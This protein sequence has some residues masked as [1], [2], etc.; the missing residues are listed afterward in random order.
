MQQILST[1]QVARLLGVKTYQI[2]YA[3]ATHALDEPA[4]RF[5]GKRVYGPDDVRRVAAHFNVGVVEAPVAPQGGT[6][7]K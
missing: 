6:E 5:L 3:H 1:G 4:F 7:A 2:E